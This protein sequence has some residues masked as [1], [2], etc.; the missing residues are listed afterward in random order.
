[1]ELAVLLTV[2][3]LLLWVLST[4]FTKSWNNFDRW[5]RNKRD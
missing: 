3:M 5:K 2:T 4:D 1:M